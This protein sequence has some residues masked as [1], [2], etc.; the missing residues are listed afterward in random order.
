MGAAGDSDEAWEGE[1]GEEFCEGG[2]VGSFGCVVGV[3]G[4]SA[5]E[6]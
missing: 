3:G 6:D 5:I 2:E 1:F 4:T